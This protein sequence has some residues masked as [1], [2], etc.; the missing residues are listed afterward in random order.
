MAFRPSVRL[1]CLAGALALAASFG[2]HDVMPM[3]A[4]GGA[5]YKELRSQHERLMARAG[6][7]TNSTPA[8]LSQP[9]DPND[10][11]VGTYRQKYYMDSSQW[12]G[13]GPAFLSIGG[14]GPVGGP[15]GACAARSP[16]AR[17]A[18]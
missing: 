12:D 8:Y 7:A 5:V 17:R 4:R 11:S 2:T 16:P 1:A 10:P 13:S 6:T 15:P 18:R 3:R 14:E 9:I